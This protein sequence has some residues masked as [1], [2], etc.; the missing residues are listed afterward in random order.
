MPAMPPDSLPECPEPRL[1]SAYVDG[2]LAHTDKARVSEHLATCQRCSTASAHLTRLRTS[3]ADPP[4]HFTRIASK[5]VSFKVTAALF[6]TAALFFVVLA[7]RGPIL[8]EQSPVR[9]EVAALVAAVGQSR[10]F[11]PRLTG[12]FRYGEPRGQDSRRSGSLSAEDLPLDLRSAAI[13]IEKRAQGSSDPLALGAFAKA[14]LVTG[15]ADKAVSTLMDAIRRAPHDSGLLSDLAAAYLVRSRDTN[16]ASD[17]ARA[18]GYARQAVDTDG[19]LTEARFNL[20]LSLEELS[21]RREATKAWQAYLETDRRSPWAMEATRHIERLAESPEARW[22]KQ[23]REIIAAGDSGDWRVVREIVA[24]FPDTAYDYVENDLVPAWTHAWLAHDAARAKDVT[25]R[26]R[27][28]GTALAETVGERMTS[29]AVAAL[30]EALA[31]GKEQRADALAR[32]NAIFREARAL[33]EQDK[34]AESAA[35]SRLALADLERGGSPFTEWTTLYLAIADYYRGDLD[36]SARSLDLLLQR[37]AARGHA[38]LTGRALRM[39]GLVQQLRG[40]LGESLDYYQKARSVFD[41]I[42]A[43]EDL[44]AIHSSLSRNFATL[45]DWK[46]AWRHRRFA[47]AGLSFART[48]RRRQTILASAADTARDENILDVAL[49]F[50]NELLADAH[51]SERA[52]AVFEGYLGRATVYHLMHR[53]NLASADLDE[54]ERW[55]SRITDAALA[56]RSEAEAKLTKGEILQRSDPAG[57]LDALT[58]SLTYFTKSGMAQRLA[59]LQLALGRAHMTEGDP[60]AA[61]T[62]F[63]E[64][65]QVLERQRARLP[66]GQ[67]RLEYFNLPWNLFDEMIDLQARQPQTWPAALTFAERARARDLL[68]AASGSSATTLVDPAKLS[69]R[70]PPDTVLVYYASLDQRLLMWVIGSRGVVPFQAPLGSLDLAREVTEYHA[71][72]QGDG[73]DEIDRRLERLFDELVRPLAAHLPPSGR[74]VI[75]PDGALHAVP[76][77]A[78]KDRSTGRYLIEDHEITLTPSATLFEVTSSRLRQL[79]TS[80]PETVLVVGNPQ[81]DPARVE[82][83]PDLPGAEAEAHDIATLYHGAVNLSGAR[84]TK[85]AFMDVAH[86]FSIVHFGGHAIANEANPLLS[87]LLLARDET[88]RSGDLFAHEIADLKFPKTELVVLAACRTAA[89]PIKKGEGPMSLARPFMATGVPS[90]LATLWDFRDRASQAFFGVFYRSL[91]QGAGPAVAARQAQLALLRNSDSTLRTPASWG[92]VVV[93]GGVRL[94]GGQ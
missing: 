89:G 14:Q 2:R 7:F 1:I 29:D 82:G 46:A 31:P 90:V 66:S 3:H 94:N 36:A 84:A 88:G 56:R 30:D 39:R 9:S 76:F 24:R 58:A 86:R 54:S 65:I 62:S 75:V 85:R 4:N 22:E 53:D 73:P 52:G 51:D 12:G 20:A 23:R 34:V 10:P 48:P 70:L 15:R 8:P 40:D 49:T 79:A 11:E 47:L 63:L 81:V 43:K 26:A 55:L 67:L 57:A 61:E 44:A 91:R 19:A 87:R 41:R 93:L 37:T 68:D 32:G 80:R 74:L 38:T 42:G 60:L 21:L 13:A 71:A 64:G 16:D 83:L 6:T 45:G 92:G 18:V 59:R 5:V 78:L 72:V 69:E 25:A 50:H 35:R 28:F 17:A 77:S 27:L 33:Y